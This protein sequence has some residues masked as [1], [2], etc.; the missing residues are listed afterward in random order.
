[1]KTRNVILMA[2]VSMT[3]ATAPQLMAN[4]VNVDWSAFSTAV[5]GEFNTYTT[6]DNFLPNYAPVAIVNHG[7]AT[8]C[9]ETD[10]NFQPGQNYYYTLSQSDGTHGQLSLG[11]AYL[12]FLFGKGWLPGYDYLNIPG[13]SRV[14]DA[15]QLQ[16]AL[17]Y[18]LGGQSYGGYPN[19]LL[20]LD[21]YYNLA[22]AKF[23]GLA[24]AQA[25]SNGAYYVDILELWNNPND[26]VP[27]Q[28]Q[29]VIVPDGGSTVLM[30]G[31]GFSLLSLAGLRYRKLPV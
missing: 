23:G 20:G 12:Y 25:P 11:A 4:N 7:F 24:N 5:A 18:L 26:T 31:M 21:P 15:Y 29:L 8:F 19:V 9:A 27:A 2:L 6:P 13:G 10:V 3:A 16:A 30:L 28:F 17:W 22:I 14:A 1:M